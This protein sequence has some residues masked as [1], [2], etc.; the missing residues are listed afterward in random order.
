MT[1]TTKAPDLDLEYVDFYSL[2]S[3]MFPHVST[4]FIVKVYD[5]LNLHNKKV[6]D[7][8]EILASEGNLRASEELGIPAYKGILIRMNDKM[9]RLK[10]FA[11]DGSL[12]CES[13]EDSFMDLANYSLL[14][15]ILFER[16]SDGSLEG[17][18]YA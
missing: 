3:R 13:V 10:K 11:R 16:Y 15:C 18:E 6:Q 4:D 5:I 17:N 7:Y 8:G 14:A 12:A 9:N 2:V 1:T